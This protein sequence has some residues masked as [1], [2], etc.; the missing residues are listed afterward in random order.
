LVT[1][2]Y[3]KTGSKVDH[4]TITNV[5]S[6]LYAEKVEVQSDALGLLS[7]DIAYGG[8][9][10]AIVDPQENYPGIDNFNSGQ[11]TPMSRQIRAFINQ[12][13]EIVHPEKPE[14]KGC[15]HV[16]WTG[17]TI[18]ADS[19]GRNA[20]FYGEKA[21]DRS[22]CGTGTSARMAQW[23]AKGHL[24]NGDEFIHESI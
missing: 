19:Q 22:P 12:R 17:N 1:A 16:M 14:I 23:Y 24:Q 21:I 15:S 6:F 13:L 7:V 2:R 4:V 11:L 18:H 8:N 9:F 5:P 10:Y 20:V 3:Q